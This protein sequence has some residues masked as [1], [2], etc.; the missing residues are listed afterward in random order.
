MKF[1]KPIISFAMSKFVPA[2]VL[3]FVACSMTSLRRE[4][5]L[6]AWN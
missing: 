5:E 1:I 2:L 3:T 6:Y 4:N